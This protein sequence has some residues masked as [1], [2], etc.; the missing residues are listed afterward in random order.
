MLSQIHSPHHF[1]KIKRLQSGVECS[2]S[3]KSI[4]TSARLAKSPPRSL[5][6]FSD[7]CHT[8]HPSI[9]WLDGLISDYPLFDESSR[10]HE[11]I[12][13]MKSRLLHYALEGCRA[14]LA[15]LLSK[16][17]SADNLLCNSINTRPDVWK[18]V[19]SAQHYGVI[20][21]VSRSDARD[22]YLSSIK[23]HPSETQ[24]I[25]EF[26]RVDAAGI[27]AINYAVHAYIRRDG[28]RVDHASSFV[29]PNAI[30]SVGERHVV[31]RAVDFERTS[32]SVLAETIP[33]WDLHDFAHLSCATL[34]PSLFGNKYQTH[35]ALLHKSLTALVR[36][37]GMS[38]GTGPKISDGMIFSQ[39]LT[40]MFTEALKQNKSYTYASLTEKLAIDLAE[41]LL[42]QKALKHLSTGN[43]MT[44][45]EPITPIQLAVLV[46]NKGYELPASEIEQRVFTRGGPT[47]SSDD[48][49][50]P[51]S[52]KER[53]EYLATSRSWMYFEVRNTIKHRAHKTAYK[54][55]CSRLMQKAKEGSDKQK[56][57]LCIIKSHLMFEDWQAGEQIN[58]WSFLAEKEW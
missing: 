30:S 57:L 46:Q 21:L 56:E 11:I 32:E 55:V 1:Q 24:A 40:P 5:T 15:P 19:L 25:D 50:L 20:Y 36:S 28:L 13:A 41:Y 48:V 45:S 54:I 29:P 31:I 43:M 22:I 8:Y 52:A 26:L 37:P 14:I 16:S 38:A 9:S 23:A 35:L 34:C 49:L 33:L 12:T 51:M 39:L 44:L 10:I 27:R 7:T 17:N 2:P 53:I 6:L 18:A 4:N 42:G 58:L 3:S 47:G